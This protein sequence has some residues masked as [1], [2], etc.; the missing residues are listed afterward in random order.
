VES[1][2]ERRVEADPSEN[3]C[4]LRLSIGVEEVEV[5]KAVVF[6]HKL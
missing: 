1:L 3:P 5:S 6:L 4:L 2:I